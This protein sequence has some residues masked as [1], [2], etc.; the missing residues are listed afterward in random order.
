M[1]PGIMLSNAG[2]RAQPEGDMMSLIASAHPLPHLDA[3]Q[4]A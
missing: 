1:E 4:M 3:M 2:E